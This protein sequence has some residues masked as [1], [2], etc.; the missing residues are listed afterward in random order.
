MAWIVFVACDFPGTLES[1]YGIEKY[2]GSL[3]I[4][5]HFIHINLFVKYF[6]L[7]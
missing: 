7:V 3:D 2:I 6:F 4:L 5:Q 1:E